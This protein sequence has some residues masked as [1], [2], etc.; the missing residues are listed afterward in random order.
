[1][2]KRKQRF[3]SEAKYKLLTVQHRQAYSAHTATAIFLLPS[4]YVNALMKNAFDL[5]LS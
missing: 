5:Q 2:V 4:T 1:M 3:V